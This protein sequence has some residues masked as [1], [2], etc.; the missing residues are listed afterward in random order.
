MVDRGRVVDMLG[1]G[2]TFGQIS[3]LSGFR[4]R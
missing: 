2:E 1:S 3:V 4:R